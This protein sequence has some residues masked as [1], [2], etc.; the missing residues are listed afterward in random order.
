MTVSAGP[1]R[2]SIRGTGP[3]RRMFMLVLLLL[4]VVIVTVVSFFTIDRREPW[5]RSGPEVLR[6]NAS[7]TG[8]AVSAEPLEATGADQ[9]APV[10]SPSAPTAGLRVLVEWD[11]GMPAAAI[12]LRILRPPQWETQT[13]EREG[14]SDATGRWTVAR[15]MPGKAAVATAPGVIQQVELIA[16]ALPEVRLR[17]PRGLEVRIAVV[18]RDGAPIA[19]AEVWSSPPWTRA[20]WCLG[21]SDRNGELLVRGMALHSTI[22]ARAAGWSSRYRSTLTP[23]F[24]A[25]GV[26]SVKLRLDT[27]SG[28]VRGLVTDADG[29][30]LGNA[31]VLIGYVEDRRVS[32]PVGGEDLI[33]LPAASGSTQDDGSFE[34]DGLLP[35][36]API[37]VRHDAH[38]VWRGIVET[39]NEVGSF[40]RVRLTRGATL[41]GIVRDSHGNSVADARITIGRFGTIVHQDARTGPDGAFRITR[42][43]P[44]PTEVRASCAGVPPVA[45]RFDFIEGVSQSWEPTF[46]TGHLLVGRI[47]SGAHDSARYRVHVSAPG[48]RAAASV[49]AL[50]FEARGVPDGQVHIT[51][52]DSKGSELFPV[53]VLD[54]VAPVDGEV[55]VPVALDPADAELRVRVVD[56]EGRPVNG[57]RFALTHDDLGVGQVV[58]SGPDGVAVSRQLIAGTYSLEVLAPGCPPV[59]IKAVRISIGESREFGDVACVAARAVRITNHP[60]P[61]DASD[62]HFEFVDADGIVVSSGEVGVGEHELV[63]VPPNADLLQFDAPGLAST[64]TAVGT[65]GTECAPTPERGSPVRFDAR[66]GAKEGGWLI[67]DIEAQQLPVRRWRA[68]RMPH[69]TSDTEVFLAPGD[70]QL[71]MRDSSRPPRSLAFTVI[72]GRSSPLHVI[73]P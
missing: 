13:P 1:Q 58:W 51:V 26:A 12:P 65:L 32:T 27:P 39:N 45:A 22:W 40:I 55:V 3:R 21:M 46:T 24:V 43:P 6:T 30:P 69:T 67:L 23:A 62:L 10:A 44:G 71:L 8:D 16:G 4:L 57:A 42:V 25:A 61:S 48:W 47:Q 37:F 53:G 63:V 19:D 73:V 41:E 60:R 33:E 14:L 36:I 20:R 34:I 7:S 64:A 70:Y 59:H 31:V 18:D 35:G 11:D 72:A 28:R 2:E 5:T 49:E 38:A 50:R 15:L 56:T 17:L 66:A 29:Q 52:Y 54:V 9:R 68:S